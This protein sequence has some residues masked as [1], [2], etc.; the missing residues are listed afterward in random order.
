[1]GSAMAS[2]VSA[3]FAFLCLLILSASSSSSSLW[4]AAVGEAHGSAHESFLRCFHERTLRS[5]IVYT[6]NTTSYFNVFRSTIQNVRF[7]SPENSRPVLIVTPTE[8][9]HAQAAVLCSRRHGLRV[10]VR[11]GG[12]DYEGL[13]YVAVPGATSSRPFVIIDLA[14][15]HAVDVDMETRTAWVGA[16]ATLGEVY[17][18]IARASPT[19][20]FPAGICPTV[21]VGG[22]VSGGGF[23]TMLR[24]YG[25]AADQVVDARVVDA[26]GRLLDRA[27]MGEDL[28]WAIRGG[29]AVSFGVVLAYRLRVVDVPRTVTVFT[30]NKTLQQNATQLVARWQNIADKFDDDLFIRVLAQA[31]GEAGRNRTVNAAFECL[32]L[33]GAQELLDYM[34]KAFPE[35]GAQ[36][37]N[38]IEL[39]WID[40]VKYFAG[41]QNRS[42]EI[43]LDRRPEF[44]SSFKAK[45]DFLEQPI[46][47]E[48]LE[49]IWEFLLNS[50]GEP[51]TM[52]IDPFGGR[53]DEVSAE[54]TPFPHRRGSRYNIQYFMRWFETEAAVT[55]RHLEWMRE[56]Y[57]FMAP[58]VTRNPRAAY[59]NYKDIDLGRNEEGEAWAGGSYV[60]ARDWGTK[61]F[62]GNFRRLAYVKGKVDPDNFFWSEQSV[63]PLFA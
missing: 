58:Y 47:V 62:K 14:N 49:H 9:A 57:G 29:G 18:Y 16:G 26:R 51:M 48:G 30:I 40:S 45:S 20:G 31:V 3:Y 43:L 4:V 60:K 12:H 8:E 17:Y 42:R 6:P 39:P 1:M 59:I 55:R 41:Y 61:Y 50:T 63:P 22:H 56:L 46:S 10:R 32:Y 11:S 34:G 33:G 23:G 19:A 25:L 54:A 7:L 2:P 27:S 53:M 52:I 35:L 37:G 21:G 15:L 44:N 13:S 24:K 5:Q 36:A 38:L 28:F